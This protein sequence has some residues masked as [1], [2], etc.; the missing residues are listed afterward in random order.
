MVVPYVASL[1]YHFR[2]WLHSTRADPDRLER[3]TRH[4]LLEAESKPEAADQA[5]AWLAKQ[6]AEPNQSRQ[7]RPTPAAAPT[8]P[9]PAPP[10]ETIDRAVP[11]TAEGTRASIPNNG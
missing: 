8:R 11:R 2:L 3:Q 7:A 10:L 6:A 5:I 1:G 9:R 4:F